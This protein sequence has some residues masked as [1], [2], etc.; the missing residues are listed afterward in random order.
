MPDPTDVVQH[1]YLTLAKAAEWYGVS[2]RTLRRRISEG[3][4][5]A[6]KVGPRSIRVRAA[7]VAALAKVIPTSGQAEE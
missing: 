2:T 6:Y 1:R 4:L 7:D 5:K 3:K